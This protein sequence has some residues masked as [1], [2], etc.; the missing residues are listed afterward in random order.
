MLCKTF[1]QQRALPNDVIV[2]EGK[3]PDGGGGLF[4]FDNERL[5]KSARSTEYPITG[6]GDC[7]ERLTPSSANSHYP[8]LWFTSLACTR[9]RDGPMDE[10]S[11]HESVN[12]GSPSGWLKMTT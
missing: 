10:S 4:S 1:V 9:T 3:N 5:Q 8:L 11:R 2:K 6:M 7:D 12:L